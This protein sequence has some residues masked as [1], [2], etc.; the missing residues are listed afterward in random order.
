MPKVKGQTCVIARRIVYKRDNCRLSGTRNN[1]ARQWRANGMGGVRGVGQQ[2]NIGDQKRPK[3][4]EKKISRPL[5][6]DVS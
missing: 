1:P 4:T 2:K 5:Q 6:H 3:K